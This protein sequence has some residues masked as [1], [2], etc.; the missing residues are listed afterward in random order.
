MNKDRTM[1]LHINTLAFS[2][3]A[4]MLCATLP[5]FAGEFRTTNH[6]VSGQYIVVLK[7]QAASLAGESGAAIR[8][9]AAAK[10]I[11]A[12][13]RATLV[14][15]FDRVLRGFVVR[16]DDK[17][18]AALL[19]DPRVDYVEEDGFVT[20]S[21]IQFNATWGLDRIDRRLLPL[22]SWYTYDTTGAG[23]HAYVID[24][25]LNLTH[26]EFT[27]RVGNGADFVGGGVND[28][29]G[30]GTHVA[31]TL[32][33]T[34]Y[35]VAKAVTIHPV[36]VLDCLGNGTFSGVIAGMNWVAA[37]R[38]LPAVAN[39][40]LGGPT[41]TSIDAAVAN[42]HNNQGVTVVVA[43][44]NTPAD[45]ACNYSPARAPL[46]ITVGSIDNNDNRSSFSKIGPCLDLFAPGRNITSAWIGSNTATNTIS[47]TSMASPHVAGVAARY[48]QAFPMASPT[49]VWNAIHSVN[50][51][52]G[53]TPSWPGVINRGTGS[54]NEQ[55]FYGSR[56]NGAD[57]GDPHIWTVNGLYYDFQTGGEF[58]AL[59]SQS[60]QVQ[61]RQRPV[62]N[63][64]WVSVNTAVAARVGKHRVTWQPG[65]GVMPD[66]AGLQL[67]IDGAVKTIPADGI[68]LGVGARVSALGGNGISIDFPDG[69]R[70]TATANWWSNQSLWYMNVRVYDTMATEGIMGALA[71]N[72][73]QRQNFSD[74]WRVTKETSLFDYDPEVTPEEFVSQPFPPDEVPAMDPK[75]V[76]LAKIACDHIKDEKL[77]KDCLFDV[78][79]TGDPVF[80][81]GGG[82]GE[83]VSKGVTATAL[84]VEDQRQPGMVTLTARVEGF[85]RTGKAPTGFMRFLADGKTIGSPVPLNA[86]GEAQW[87]GSLQ[88][89]G[90]RRVSAE[91]VPA[92][93]SPMLP[94][95]SSAAHYVPGRVQ[96]Q[97]SPVS[98]KPT[99]SK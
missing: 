28:C 96:Q 24:T 2:I 84:R 34:T 45:N 39:M 60:M 8:I 53:I 94:S 20:P 38:I 9:P 31:G 15:S 41:N 54:P 5:A 85:A 10:A 83:I 50:N 48:L 93:D 86:S 43:A 81:E 37:N 22:D 74:K 21:T 92:L 97:D 79:T 58:V 3:S 63:F 26:N 33:G 75:N 29:Q 27:G 62:D 56:N 55:L 35:G 67:R 52:F 11:S 17:A 98:G 30:H 40:S 82:V 44:G 91:Y 78:G 23:V 77:H 18:L 76:E 73:W 80:A 61:T 32:G 36:R 69:S 70:M 68:D 88:L 51:I 57:E 42:L 14:R 13:H 59:R 64:P 12:Q 90:N 47:G 6:P 89:I 99:V 87:I 95:R 66:P 25:G 19:A 65:T 4:A 16:A 7:P 71:P 49:Q 1:K 46:A 72:E